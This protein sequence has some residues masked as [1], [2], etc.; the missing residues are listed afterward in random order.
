MRRFKVNSLILKN[1]TDATMIF[2]LKELLE[3]RSPI[4]RNLG[5][6]L[7]EL[8]DKQIEEGVRTEISFKGIENCSS[9]FL[10]S[11]I[12]RLY[13]K[14]DHT[15]IENLLSFSEIDNKL[16]KVQINDTILGA[17]DLNFH[18]ELIELAV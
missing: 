5:K 11:S 10:N 15:R 14:H 1:S 13:L 4:S 3:N 17:K 2:I 7:F 8:L 9:A 12:G 16:I 6:I 18:Q